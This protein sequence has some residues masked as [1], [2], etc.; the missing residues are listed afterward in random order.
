[1]IGIIKLIL[2]VMLL[3]FSANSSYAKKPTYISCKADSVSISGNKEPLTLVGN[4]VCKKGESVYFK[5]SLIIYDL[6]ENR[7][8]VINL[9]R[10]FYKA[11]KEYINRISDGKGVFE[12]T[13]HLDHQLK[14]GLAKDYLSDTNLYRELHHEELK[15]TCPEGGCV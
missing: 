1:M 8:F 6:K 12:F 5:A 10:G 9:S 14:T 2:P 11:N 13:N 4:V 15:R 3:L 7:A